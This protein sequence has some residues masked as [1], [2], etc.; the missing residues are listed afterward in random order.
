[1][2]LRTSGSRIEL[3]RSAPTRSCSARIEREIGESK[4]NRCFA[5][6]GNDVIAK[7][8][9]KKGNIVRDSELVS[10]FRESQRYGRK[11]CVTFS[12]LERSLLQLKHVKW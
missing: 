9:L 5:E 1:M 6:T 4:F 12:F 2:R 10:L 8:K 3:Y 11:S 7:K